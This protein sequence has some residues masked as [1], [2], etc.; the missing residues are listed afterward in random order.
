MKWCATFY[1]RLR[2]RPRLPK[3]D[4]RAT[5]ALATTVDTERAPASAV[6]LERDLVVDGL[7]E[8][9][10][11]GG[12]GTL[13]AVAVARRGV[14]GLVVLVHA[15][16]GAGTGAAAGV[17]HGEHAVEALQHDL[18]GVAI[19]AVLALPL[20]RLQRALD[21]Q[22]GALFHVLLHD[23]AEA[24]IEDDDRVPLGLLLALA[25]GLV[26]PAL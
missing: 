21:V 14:A 5:M 1:C 8:A 6:G 24:L 13:G 23:A 3:G 9:L 4:A 20:A 11:A 10:A 17:E 25:R 22:L 2:A 15:G 26:A 18:G 19:L 7:V 16:A 12:G